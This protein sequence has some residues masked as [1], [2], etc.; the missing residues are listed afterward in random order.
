MIIMSLYTALTASLA[1]MLSDTPV[2]MTVS[3]IDMVVCCKDVI[4]QAAMLTGM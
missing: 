3:A 1:N 2:Q 4:H